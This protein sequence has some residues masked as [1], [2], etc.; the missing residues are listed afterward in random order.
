MAIKEKEVRRDDITRVIDAGKAVAIPAGRLLIHVI[1]QKVI[2]DDQD[3]IRDPIGMSGVRLE[4]RV[5]TD[6]IEFEGGKDVVSYGTAL[7]QDRSFY[8]QSSL[9]T[10]LPTQ[11]FCRSYD[12][13]RA[14]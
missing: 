6:T 8:R 14:L 4:V 9:R 2:V 13:L 5:H 11:P 7:S 3:G 12:R 10:M 1:P